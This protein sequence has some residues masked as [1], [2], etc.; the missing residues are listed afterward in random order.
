MASRVNWRGKT[1]TMLTVGKS[2]WTDYRTIGSALD[3]VTDNA[4]RMA[5][6]EVVGW[7]QGASRW[8]A[9]VRACGGGGGAAAAGRDATADERGGL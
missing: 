2:G 9:V 8:D 1:T 7:T 6:N 4:A 5:A 3:S